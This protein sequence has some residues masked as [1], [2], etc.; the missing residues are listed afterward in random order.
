MRNLRA[1]WRLLRALL[2]LLVGIAVAFWFPLLKSPRRRACKRWWS[3]GMLRAL[4][5]EL[6][7]D[8]RPRPGGLLLV[9]N[10]VSWLDILAINAVHPA[11]FVSKAEIKSWPVIGWLVTTAGTLYIER[12]QRRDALRVVHKMAKVLRSGQV[13]A[14]FPEGTT[15]DGRSLRPFHA[16]L[17]QA[18]ITT[19]TPVQPVALRYSDA[20][21][22]VS[23]AAAY[24][25]DMTLWRSLLSIA[26][27]SGL[28][29]QVDLLPPQAS[30]KA[31]RRALAESLRFAILHQLVEPG[32]PQVMAVQP[33]TAFLGGADSRQILASGLPSALPVGKE[34][35]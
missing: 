27:A 14:V 30:G 23:P 11:R 6:R 8:G 21:H 12:G 1:A 35:A 16:N 26:R 28:S 2:H 9:A 3:A 15:T 34:S 33:A 19:D 5:V 20:S 17:L 25:G 24:V 7:S 10:H 13:V 22:A 4:G 29:V 31:E 32:R 18:A